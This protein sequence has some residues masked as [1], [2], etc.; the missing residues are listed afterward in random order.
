MLADEDLAADVRLFLQEL[1]PKY[2]GNLTIL[3]RLLHLDLA[4]GKKNPK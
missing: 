3:R 2:K 1:G 4:K